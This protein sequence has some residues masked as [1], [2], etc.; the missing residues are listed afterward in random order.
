VNRQVDFDEVRNAMDTLLFTQDTKD[1]IWSILAA[2][3]HLGNVAFTDKRNPDVDEVAK[4]ANKQTLA[5]AA[6]LVGCDPKLL[7]SCLTMRKLSTGN[8]VVPYKVDEA[9]HTRDAMTKT[10][11]SLL[12]EW[13][14]K[15]INK[16][17]EA[18]GTSKNGRGRGG[19]GMS[20]SIIALL[21]IFGFESFQTNSFEQLCINYCN[22]KLNNHFNEHV[23][24][25]EI[26]AYA[27][28]GVV[29]PNLVF[30]DNKPIL[31]FIEGKGDGLYSILDEQVNR[32]MVNGTDAK[33]L[34][35]VQQMHGSHKHY[36]MPK[37]NN[38][39]DPDTRNC[40]GV[41]HF[42]GDVF[43]NVRDFVE[44]NKVCV[45]RGGL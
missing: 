3:L 18:G 2:V 24:K 28:E 44:K 43:Y 32:I 8:V 20:D 6:S 40:F 11:Y 31:D 16:T 10:L 26:A 12:F 35:K 45:W 41:V 29:V 38:C 27:A 39:P 25:G 7:T 5:F 23:F 1:T 22:E 37:R 34:S 42:A 21:D 4:V 19:G 33:F 9:G 15:Q 13:I 14:I 30:K 36:I 17:L